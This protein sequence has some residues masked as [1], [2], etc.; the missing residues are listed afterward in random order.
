MQKALN[1]REVL[2]DS[3]TNTAN[4]RVAFDDLRTT[5]VNKAVTDAVKNISSV[6]RIVE[7]DGR[8]IQKIYPIYITHHKP[9]YY[10]DFSANLYQPTKHFAGSSI[11]TLV[12]DLL[13]IWSMTVFLAVALYFD[14]LRKLVK[15]LENRRKYRRKERL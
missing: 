4:E 11:D 12:F 13:V 15:T 6:D 5:Y 14:L 9:R 7:Y 1:E 2:V 3:L 8:F 10:F